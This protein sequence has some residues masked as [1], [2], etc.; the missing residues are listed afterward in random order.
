V[1]LPWVAVVTATG[2]L[3]PKPAIAVVIPAA[4]QALWLLIR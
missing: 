1:T 2:W 3:R 4:T